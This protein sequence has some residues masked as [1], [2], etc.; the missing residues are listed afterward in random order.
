MYKEQD[1]RCAICDIK[2]D[3]Q[4]LGYRKRQAL[5]VDHDHET[6]AVRG[7]L[8]GACNLGIGK[9]ADDPAIIQNAANYLIKHNR[10]SN[11]KANQ[12]RKKPSRRS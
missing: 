12:R 7:L 11:G 2:G 5:C 6:K 9:L 3:V 10:K 4:E 8:C 1:G